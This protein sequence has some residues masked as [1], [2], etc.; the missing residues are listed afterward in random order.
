MDGILV[1]VGVVVVCAV[2]LVFYRIDARTCLEMQSEL[3][4]RRADAVDE[5]SRTMSDGGTR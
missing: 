4:A 2:L 1:F 3:E 5:S